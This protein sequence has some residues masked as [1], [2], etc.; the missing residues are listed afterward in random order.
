MSTASDKDRLAGCRQLRVNPDF[1]LTY[2]DLAANGML[3]PR[4]SSEL[5]E[6]TEDAG[7][8]QRLT[9][10]QASTILGMSP[11]YLRKLMQEGTMPHH[12]AELQNQ[13]MLSDVEKYLQDRIAA[14]ETFNQQT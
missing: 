13:I 10:D 5:P 2:F 11:P 1:D 6:V 4:T 9:V 7:E 8:D 12:E 3:D 14:T